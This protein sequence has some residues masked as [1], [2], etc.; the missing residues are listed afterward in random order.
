[1]R[2]RTAGA[3]AAG[4][5]FAPAVG[6][7]VALVHRRRQPGCRPYHRL[8]RRVPAQPVQMPAQTGTAH[9]RRPMRAR[10]AES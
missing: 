9:Q 2:F 8:E 1:M 4:T 10:A 6:T 3:A 5:D 7:A